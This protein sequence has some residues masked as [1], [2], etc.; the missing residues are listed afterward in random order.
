MT[1][2]FEIPREPS[3]KRFK[4]V[5]GI[6]L[7]LII[8]VGW[9]VSQVL[10]DADRMSRQALVHSNILE[11]NWKLDDYRRDHGVYPPTLSELVIEPTTERCDI[12]EDRFGDAIKYKYFTNSFVIMVT[13]KPSLFGSWDD[14]EYSTTN[15]ETVY[16]T[17]KYRATIVT[18]VIS[19]GKSK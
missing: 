17:I 14:I 5:A 10:H 4:V 13:A 9:V 8:V 12:F 19:F 11:L 18:N 6:F 3:A 16:E 15:G 7:L 2:P 1:S